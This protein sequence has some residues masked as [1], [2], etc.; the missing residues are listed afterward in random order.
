MAA[1]WL[2]EDGVLRYMPLPRYNFVPVGRWRHARGR[3]HCGGEPGSTLLGGYT[4]DS[5]RAEGSSI[6]DEPGEC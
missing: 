5:V 2:V 6:I 1:V 3:K 4:P